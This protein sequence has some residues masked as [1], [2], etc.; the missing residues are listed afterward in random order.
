MLKWR[1]KLHL[2]AE[3]SRVE[4]AFMNYRRGILQGNTLSL[5]LFVIS[6]NPLSHNPA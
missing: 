5:I 3:T 6:V 2:Y 4:T 1:I